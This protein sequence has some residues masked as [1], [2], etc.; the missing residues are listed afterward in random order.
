[1]EVYSHLI[2]LVE[3]YSYPYPPDKENE[4]LWG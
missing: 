3:S 1:M 2:L 4:A